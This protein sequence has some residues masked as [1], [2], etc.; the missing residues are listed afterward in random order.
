MGLLRWFVDPL[1]KITEY[2]KDNKTEEIINNTNN[3]PQ[4]LQSPIETKPSTKVFRPINF[5]QYIGQEKAK[6][7]LKNYIQGTKNRNTIFPHLLIHSS[8]GMGKTTLARIVAN[9]LQVE[10]KEYITSSITADAYMFKYILKK[11]NGN[12]IFLDEVHGIDRNSAEQIYSMIE[13]FTHNGEAIPP[14]TLIGAT[15]ELG[16]ILE[17]RRP[18]YD[19]FKIVIEL[20]DYTLEDMIKIIKQY[21]ENSFPDYIDEK[22]YEV[23]AKNS[24]GI[25]RKAIR[26][27]D[28]T[29]YFGGDVQEVLKSFGIIKDGYSLKDLKV[30]EYLFQ[31]QKGVGIQGISSYLNTSTQ[32]YLYEIEPYLLKNNIIIRTPRGRKI[33]DKGIQLIQELSL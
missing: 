19:R 21:K 10:M 8:A 29:I 5:N 32:N 31:N 27:L 30:L 11:A 9:E 1:V 28:A 16:E 13:D 23:I 3:T 18:F 26:L 7:I 22:I 25:P 2:L 12:I 20:E 6:A 17:T 4:V 24:Q 33:S 14:F 15:T